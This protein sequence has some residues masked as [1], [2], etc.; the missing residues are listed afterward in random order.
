MDEEAIASLGRMRRVQ[1]A[2]PAR[3]ADVAMAVSSEATLAYRSI[4]V[5]C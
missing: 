2:L 3:A 1:I 4:W 5:C